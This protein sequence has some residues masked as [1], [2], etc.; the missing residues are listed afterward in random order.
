MDMKKILQ[1]VDGVASKPVEGANDMKKFLSVVTEGKGPLNRLT[2]AES[3]AVNQYTAPKTRETIT[4]PILNVA[5]DAKPSMV[6]KYFKQ[7]EEEFAESKTR[8]KDRARQLAERVIERIVPGE[9]PA[10]GINRLTGKPNVPDA[11]MPE[12]AAP[13][14]PVQPLS[15][16]Y[17]PRFKN[18][19]EP[20][21]IDI[22]GTVYKFA[23]RDKQGPGT[24]EVIKVPAAVIGI[25]GLGAVNVELGKDGLYYPAPK[26]ESVSEAPI[27][28]DPAE[29]NN[30]TIHG[31]EKA[32]AMSLKGRIMSARA[33]LKEL[34]QLADS[35]ELLVWEKITQLH[36]GGMFMG[37][38]QNLEQIRHGIEELAAKRKKGGIQ[39]RGIDN[40]I[41]EQGVG[42]AA[43]A[44]QQ[45]A[46]AIAKKKEHKT[47]ESL[48][49]DNPCWKGYKPVGTK[50]K[51]G[52]TVPNCVPK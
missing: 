40:N 22:G 30:P 9:E 38:A 48:K 41:G 23:G 47:D 7:V 44:A 13:T 19:P 10:P 6:G 49:T 5:K 42:E 52:K 4:S 37:L 2:A 14:A 8:Y 46:I 29:P 16:R 33:Q 50:K 25:R 17:D 20:Y 24:G 12:P 18:G 51:G 26:T 32:N 21:T 3:M 11:M 15:S 35:N 27:A 28:M 43:S 45:A 39:S 36:K 1:A 31:H 34:A